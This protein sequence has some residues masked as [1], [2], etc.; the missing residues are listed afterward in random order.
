MICLTYN[1]SRLNEWGQCRPVQKTSRSPTWMLRPPRALDT[2][3]KPGPPNVAPGKPQSGWLKALNISS[4]N[5]KPF[6]SEKK[7][8]LSSERSKLTT[9]SPRTVPRPPVPNV[10]VAGCVK[11]DV[12]NQRASVRSDD[13]RLGLRS[14]S[15]RWAPAEKALVLFVCVVTVVG[16]P[17][18]ISANTPTDQAPAITPSGPFAR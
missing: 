11:A 6:C 3:P 7:K 12:S 14:I 9:P 15:A 18:C 5:W 13:F 4:L 8:F 10:N 1:D 16:G 17:V 2:T